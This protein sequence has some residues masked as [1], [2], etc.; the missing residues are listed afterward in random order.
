MSRSHFESRIDNLRYKAVAPLCLGRF[1]A[2]YRAVFF[3]VSFLKLLFISFLGFLFFY[4]MHEAT[5][6]IP[7]IFGSTTQAQGQKRETKIAPRL[8][9]GDRTRVIICLEGRVEDLLQIRDSFMWNIQS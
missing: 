6:K 9:T 4:K 5:L 3:F 1:I 7:H 2:D 8:G